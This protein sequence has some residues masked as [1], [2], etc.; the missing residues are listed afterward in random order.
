MLPSVSVYSQTGVLPIE[1]E[2]GSIGCVQT[3]TEVV[4]FIN[5]TSQSALLHD[6]LHRNAHTGLFFVWCMTF[7]G[8]AKPCTGV[9]ILCEPPANRN[10]TL[11]RGLH[12]AKHKQRRPQ[13]AAVHSLSHDMPINGILMDAVRQPSIPN[14][15]APLL[16]SPNPPAV[17]KSPLTHQRPIQPAQLRRRSLSRGVRRHCAAVSA[18]PRRPGGIFLPAGYAVGN[19]GRVVVGAGL[20]G[21][22]D[23]VEE[24]VAHLFQ[25]DL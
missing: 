9:G 19:H 6:A 5:T 4:D 10:L 2:A 15:P 22:V 8:R 12:I 18:L 23:G 25:C 13:D 7:R 20:H 21:G 16:R 17:L 1:R 11:T 24:P 14:R 3:A